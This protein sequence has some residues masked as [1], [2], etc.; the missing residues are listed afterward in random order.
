MPRH[1]GPCGDKRRNEIDRRLLEMELSGETFRKIS[2]DFGYSE[3]SLRRHKENHLVIDLATVKVAKEEARRK[4]EAEV[5][6]RETEKALAEVKTEVQTG[7]AE[8]LENAANFLDQLKEVRNKA[9]TLLELAEEAEDLRA[10]GTLLRELREQIRLWAELEKKM[11]ENPPQV[12]ITLNPEWIELR[13]T[14]LYALDPYPEAKLAIV[15]AIRGPDYDKWD[16]D[17]LNPG[18]AEV[19]S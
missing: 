19:K 15:R 4:A 5:Q 16:N 2:H 1:C 7:M 12:S 11:A 14:I 10:A 9:A 8:R 6:A 18:S 17:G 3:Y 13:T